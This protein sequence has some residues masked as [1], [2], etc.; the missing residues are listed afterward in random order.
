M[1]FKGTKLVDSAPAKDRSYRDPEEPDS[2]FL[3]FLSI[4]KR[5]SYKT[6]VM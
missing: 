3:K 4:D 2:D 6:K 1:E 5:N